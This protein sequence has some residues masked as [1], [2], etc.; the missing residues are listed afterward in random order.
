MKK[1]MV[2]FSGIALVISGV[3]LYV[4][5]N[6]FYNMGFFCDEFGTSPAVI[7]GGW[8]WVLCEWAALFLLLV[9]VILTAAWLVY[10]I[11]QLVSSKK[12]K[13]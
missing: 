10:S 13:T 7:Y 5:C 2:V 8:N 12:K 6:L 4:Q 1:L 9:L 11:C 3:C